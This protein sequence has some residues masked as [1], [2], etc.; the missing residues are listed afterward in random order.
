[1]IVGVSRV[2]LAR[3]EGGD[4]QAPRTSAKLSTGFLS[5][6]LGARLFGLELLGLLGPN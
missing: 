5:E 4:G 2:E 6:R 1:M 3:L